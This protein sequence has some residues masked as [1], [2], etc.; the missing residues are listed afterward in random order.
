MI[1]KGQFV[2]IHQIILTPSQRAP[3]VP[4]DTRN[5]PLELWVKG[6][7]LNDGKIGDTVEIKTVTGRI[8]EGT[9]TE[10]NPRYIHDFGDYIPELDQ[11]TCQLKDILY[12]GDE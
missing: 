1:K 3:Q 11:V 6:Y 12:G 9:L 10:V 5:V 4:E 8:L 2:Q 7:L